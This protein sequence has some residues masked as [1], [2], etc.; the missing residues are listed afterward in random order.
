ML[1]LTRTASQAGSQFIGWPEEYIVPDR[2]SETCQDFIK[3]KILPYLHDVDA[4]V[5]VGCEQALDSLECPVGNLAFTIAPRGTGILGFYGKQHPVTMIGERSCLLDGYTSYTVSSQFLSGTAKEF[6][7]STLICYDMDF[8][9]SSAIVADLGAAMILN[10]SEDWAAARGH[11]AA[12]VFRAVENR[13][14]VAKTDWGWDSAI[15]DPFGRIFASYNSNQIQREILT[16]NVPILERA[17]GTYY[18]SQH[19]LPYTGFVI[20]GIAI[21]ARLVKIR[22]S[23]RESNEFQTR[24]IVGA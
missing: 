20:L 4:Y 7:F 5:V 9:D 23:A 14:A 6:K 11:F 12:S 10:P 3:D 24:L 21:L 1:N 15:I 17:T 19:V 13:I 16:A 18:F 8:P 22:A 2:V